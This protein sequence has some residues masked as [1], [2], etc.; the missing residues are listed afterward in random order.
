M[1]FDE[2]VVYKRGSDIQVIRIL[3]R[4]ETILRFRVHVNIKQDKKI[5]NENKKG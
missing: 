4:P 3:E 1:L 2:A 5:T